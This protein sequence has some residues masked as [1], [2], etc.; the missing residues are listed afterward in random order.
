MKLVNITQTQIRKRPIVQIV[1][2]RQEFIAEIPDQ[3]QEF[4]R[5]ETWVTKSTDQGLQ[6]PR[7]QHPQQLWN[8]LVVHD[9]TIIH[10]AGYGHP[11]PKLTMGTICHGALSLPYL[12]R[13]H[14][15]NIYWN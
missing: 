4:I 9:S 1:A 3:G 8:H 7:L 2:I 5:W 6:Q 10:S 12:P 14:R 11:H 15:P 13:I